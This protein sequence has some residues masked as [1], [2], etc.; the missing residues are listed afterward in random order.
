MSITRTCWFHEFYEFESELTDQVG[1]SHDP[2][3][4]M[5]VPMEKQWK[6]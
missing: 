6:L 3:P 2:D 1:G 5:L 4:Q